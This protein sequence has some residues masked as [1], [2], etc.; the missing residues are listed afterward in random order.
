MVAAG[1]AVRRMRGGAARASPYHKF[2]RPAPQFESAPEPRV[3]SG[4]RRHLSGKGRRTMRGGSKL[5]TGGNEL[6]LQ[7][8]H[9][10][11]GRRQRGGAVRERGSMMRGSGESVGAP[12]QA[13]DQQGTPSTEADISRSAGGALG[14][15]ENMMQLQR[16]NPRPQKYGGVHVAPMRLMVD[17][18]GTIGQ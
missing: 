12:P 2:T 8:K 14:V 4:G 1:A 13:I 18:I 7:H 17:K 11:F 15:G 9:V 6:V 10:G 16:I 5:L 3:V